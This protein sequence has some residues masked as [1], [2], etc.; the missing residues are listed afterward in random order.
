MKSV[1]FPLNPVHIDIPPLRAYRKRPT[2]LAWK[3][4]MTA[5]GPQ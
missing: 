5:D 2:L 4:Q 3:R 1:H